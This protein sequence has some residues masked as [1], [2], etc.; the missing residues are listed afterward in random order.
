MPENNSSLIYISEKAIS[1]NLRFIRSVVKPGVELVSVIKGNA[2]GHGI[3][4][5]VP[6]LEKNGVTRFAVYSVGEARAFNMVAAKSSRLMIMG[7]VPAQSL[8][9][10]IEQEYEFYTVDLLAVKR[11]AAAAA[12]IGRRARIHL[13]FETGMNRTGIAPD[14]IP[15]LVRLLQQAQDHLLIAGT[16]SHLAGAE[17]IANLYRIQ[18]QISRFEQAVNALKTAGVNP[19]KIHLACSAAMLRYPHTQYDMVRVGILH[20]GFWPNAETRMEILTI[21]RG[22]FVDPLIGILSWH[23]EVMTIKEVKAGDY[24]G[25]GSYFLAN[26]DMRI[27]VIPVGYSSGYARDLSNQGRVLI[28]GKRLGVVGMVNMN[29]I[30]VD[31]TDAGDIKPGDDVVL[32]GRQGEK[33][34]SVSSFS[35]MSSQLNYEMLTRLSES[36][37]RIIK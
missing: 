12:R 26:K 22:E 5:V 24:I 20:Y 27:A 34:I 14:D 32:I 8:E 7:F 17:D 19:G 16:C 18:A 4:V 23:S 6:L 30:T 31:I 33:Y 21:E 37:P 28:N 13:E 1:N 2:Y 29:M 35:E 36:I 15:E 3:G 9:W 11:A 25:Y 10:V